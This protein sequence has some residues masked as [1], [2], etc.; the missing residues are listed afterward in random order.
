MS[1]KID[2]RIVNMKFDGGQFQKGVADTSRS[3]D[4]LKKSL[5]LPGA[6]KGLQEVAAFAS[7]GNMFAPM[8][9]GVETIASKFTALS[10]IGITALT[11]IANR[12]VNAG[13]TITKSLT[14]DPIK[15]GLQEYEMNLNGIQTILANTKSK[16]ENIDTVGAALDDLNKYSDQTIYNFGQMVTGIKTLTTA[17]ADLNVGVDVVKGFANAAALAGIGAQEMASAMQFGLN[18]AITKGRMMTQDWMSLETAGIAG[19][20]FKNAMLDS[21]RVNGIAVDDM[22]AKNGSFRESLKEG[23]LTTEIMTQGLQ[24][25]TG[26][27]TDEQLK[28]MGYTDEQIKGIQEMA[29]TAVESATKVKTATQLMDTLR[30]ASQSGWAKS[31]QIMVGNLDEAKAL[32][33]GISDEIGGI[34]NSQADYRNNLLQMFKDIGGREVLLESFKNI[35][36]AFK[37]YLMPISSAWREIFPPIQAGNLLA[38]A[39]AFR[40]FT[41]SLRPSGEQMAQIKRIFQGVFA[42]FD[43]GRMI[44]GQIIKVLGRLFGAA[45]E[46]AGGF[47]EIG[48]SVGDWL[49]KVRDAIKDGTALEKFFKRLGDVLQWPIDKLRE[50]GSWTMDTIGTLD[51]AAAWEAVANAFR[52]VGEFF[53]PVWDFLGEFFANAKTVIT[54][55]FKTMDFGGLVGLLN[56]GALAGIGGALTFFIGK[57][58]YIFNRGPSGIIKAIRD[59]FEEVTDTFA[60]LQMKLKSEALQKIAIAIAI[61]TASV[62]AL[63]FV[64]TDKLFIALG[65]MTVMFGQLSAMLVAMD[66]LMSDF[67]PGKMASL[68]GAMIL[69]ATAMLI[70]SSAIA[71]MGNLSWEELTRGLIGMGVGLGALMASME[72]MSGMKKKVAEIAP[73]LITMSIAML[74]ISTA[75]KIM[76]TISWEEMARGLGIFVIS[77]GSLVGAMALM[78]KDVTGAGLML[79]LAGSLVMIALALKVFSTMSWDDIFRSVAVMGATIGI[80][81]AAMA[82]LDTLKNV[83]V[84]AATMLAMAAAINLLIVPM[85]AFATMSWDEIVRALVVLGGSLAILAGAMAL[86]GLPVVLLGA[87][88]IVAASAA[89]M[90]LAPALKILGSMSWDDIGRGLALLASALGILAVGGI[91]LLPAI[92][93]FVAL[94]GAILMIGVGTLA[95][96]IGLTMFAAGFLALA[97][98]AVLGTEAIKMVVISLVSLIPMA[99]A[100]FAQGI[101]DFALVIANGGT[102]FTLAMTT[103]LTSLITAIGTVGPQIIDTLWNLVVLMVAKLTENIPLFVDSGLRM[104]GGIMDGIAN[105]LPSLINSAVSIVVELVNGIANNIQKIIDA[106][107]NLVVNFVDGIGTAI[108][109]NSGKFVRAGSKLFRAIVDGV[110]QAIEQ[111]GSDLAWAGGRIGTALLNGAFNALGINSPSKEFFKVGLSAIEGITKGTNENLGEVKRAGEEVGNTAVAALNRSMAA[112]EAGMPTML[113]LTPTIRPVLDLTGVRNTAGAISTMMSVPTLRVE[114]NYQ[115]AT[116]LSDEYREAREE[117]EEYERIRAAEAGVTFNQYNTSPKPISDVDVY[118]QTKTLISTAREELKG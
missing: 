97:G 57:I 12:A 42:I 26:E 50:L 11:N 7:R 110:A 62:I 82:I 91:L 99:M 53:A 88:G 100:A 27:L 114:G 70:M 107:A 101:I 116:S 40:D 24:K 2:E 92:P 9:N 8:I 36:L 71:I 74:L 115:T 95:A 103:L 79:A 47:L 16:G 86:M 34:I 51:F 38:M 90:M 80:M 48:A 98:A 81:V 68:A 41:K 37:Q 76:S 33:T 94:G 66:K 25:F 14:I 15:T 1:S 117:R 20:N 49:V 72:L 64:D 35:W 109:N 69:L 54:D 19:E 43:I 17:G 60:A 102:E 63:S 93:A 3:L 22:I 10:I 106:A 32:Y 104:I 67:K 46:G 23:W 108:Q 113:E 30:E 5:N 45:T 78:K 65:A 44:V 61:L 4:G 58:L 83:P 21:A 73:A 59:I 52:K 87:V 89:M 13:I 31:W 55:F 77:L 28:S 6:T 75:I 29:R 39:K 105:N 118:R 112:L 85:K 96:G 111:G 56:V 18:Q 84:G